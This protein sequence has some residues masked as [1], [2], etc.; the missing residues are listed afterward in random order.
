MVKLST[1]QKRENL[2]EVY[3]GEKGAG[4]ASHDYLIVKSGCAKLDEKKNKLTGNPNDALLAIHFQE[5][6]RNDVKSDDGVLDADLL[7]IVRDRLK[8]F[9]SGEFATRENACA[10]T[11]IEEALMWMNKRVE[12]RIERNVLGTYNK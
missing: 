3:A 4:G 5:G 9:Q 8:G 10:L 1:I 11:H 12:D 7:E 6:A 2:N